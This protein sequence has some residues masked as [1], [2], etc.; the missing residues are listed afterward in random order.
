MESGNNTD[1]I[2]S[3]VSGN[4]VT[5][6]V[7]GNL[8]IE[9]KQESSL[10]DNQSDT[11]GAGIGSAGGHTGESASISQGNTDSRWQSVIS[12]AGIYAGMESLQQ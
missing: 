3:K 8:H 12:Q 4:K 9:S 6:N 2:G 10:Y 1:L 11:M 5:V 7:G